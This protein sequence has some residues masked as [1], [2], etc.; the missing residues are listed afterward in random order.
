[1]WVSEFLEYLALERNYSPHTVRSYGDDLTEFG[2]FC[3][4]NLGVDQ[5]DTL[6][7]PLI[8]T[9]IIALVNSG[10]SN[11]TI[12]RKMASLKAYYKFL[13]KTGHIGASPMA[14]HK[15]LK[16]PS[17]VEVP[18]SEKEMAKVLQ[19]VEYPEGFEGA[20][21]RAII[22][23]L[24]ATGMRRAELVNLKLGDVDLARKQVKVLGKR[25]KERM[26][27]LLGSLE[28]VLQEYM[29]LRREV[30]SAPD[31]RHFFLLKS[32]YKIYENLVY[33]VINKY[34]SKVSSKVKRSPHVLR[35]TF[36]THLLNRGGDMNSVKE[37]LGHASL[38][39][40]QIYV[41]NSIAELKKV[42]GAAHPR[43][44]S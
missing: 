28:P 39:S 20:R 31:E 15:S 18:F 26:L 37:L 38:A 12:N 25:N 23:L 9:W 36:A 34:L 2:A 35:H 4:S 33:R 14:T 44:K 19:A 21:D 6:T 24:Y 42:H 43:N 16:T 11:R 13:L 32:G 29:D 5:I 41:H 3:A 1:M 8:R 10:I 27:P 17:K 7:Y 30:V 40:T 22:E